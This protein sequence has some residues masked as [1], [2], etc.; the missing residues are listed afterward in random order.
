M[1][2]TWIYGPAVGAVIGY[3][4]NDIAIRMLFRPREAK[5]LFGHK[6]PFTPGLIP[7]ERARMAKAVGGTVSGELLNGEVLEK[8]LLSGGVRQK[9]EDG[10]SELIARAAAEARAVREILPGNAD[11]TLTERMSGWMDSLSATICEKLLASDFEHSAASAVIDDLRTR[12]TQS[13][14]SPL[15]L[16]WDDRFSQLLTERLAR[17]LRDMATA[18][19]AELIRELIGTAVNGLLDTPVSELYEQHADKVADAR[20]WLLTEYEKLVRGQL[21][22]MLGAI[23]IAGIVEERINSLDA[24]QLETLLLGLMKRELRA[25]VWLGALLGAVMGVANAV[26]ALL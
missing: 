26:I 22:A 19:G 18:K 3:I 24:A 13:P 2:L 5:Y 11:G 20:A 21:Q 17:T 10:L 6:V 25:I 12:L 9:I 7:K 8:A 23:D 1:N 15:R 14:I 16:F 4:T